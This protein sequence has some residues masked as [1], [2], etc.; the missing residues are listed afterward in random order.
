VGSAARGDRATLVC[1][2]AHPD[3]E[4]L[5]TGGTIAR[6]AAEG[7]RVVVVVATAGEQGL[8]GEPATPSGIAS[9]GQALGDRRLRELADSA[10]VLGVARVEVLG[11]ADSGSGPRPVSAAATD[12][13]TDAATHAVPDGAPTVAFAD[14]DVD[15]AAHRLAAILR[16]E[17]AGVLTVYDPNGGY[18][19]RDHVQVHRVGY[20][21]A[22][23]AGTP[24][25]LEATV[26]RT[27]FARGVRL[28]RLAG[29]VLPV[30]QL[31]DE[32]AAY[33]AREH[34]THRV[35]VAAY[36]DAKRAALRAHASQQGGGP[37]T[38]SILLA[39]PRPLA[40]LVLGTEWFRERGREGTQ[41]YGDVFA[42]VPR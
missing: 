39:L 2:H 1:F 15:E 32:R 7:H 31:P 14:A 23:L 24:V 11:Y 26:D 36:L 18:G 40:R 20:R 38:V 16:E 35:D 29:R 25:V 5:L 12:A 33:T 22:E 42:T 34:I 19:H 30:P 13:V 9:P 3:D 37:R 28:G 27:W 4:A 17:R 41:R 6:A 10:R 21:A 8:T